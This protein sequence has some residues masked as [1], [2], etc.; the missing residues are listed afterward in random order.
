MPKSGN[1]YKANPDARLRWRVNQALNL[2]ERVDTQRAVALAKARPRALSLLPLAIFPGNEPTTKELEP[3]IHTAIIDA[4]AQ[5]N[6]IRLLLTD[7]KGTYTAVTVAAEDIQIFQ[8]ELTQD[9][10]RAAN[11]HTYREVDY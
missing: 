9:E 6:M 2:L 3:L 11:I 8:H 1:N 5:G 10:I 7:A 4:Q